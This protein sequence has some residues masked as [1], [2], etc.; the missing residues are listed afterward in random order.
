MNPSNSDLEFKIRR[1][2]PADYDSLI[3]LWQ[4]SDSHIDPQGRESRPNFL[5]QLELFPD[6]YLVAVHAD[7][8]VGVVLGSHDGRKGWINRLAVHP[9]SRRRK[10]AQGL[11]SACDTA[12]RAHGIDLVAALVETHNHS[13]ASLFRRLAYEELPV[14]YFRKPNPPPPPL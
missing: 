4:I 3:E 5:R 14:F 6:L 12:I 8:I 11:V 7:R 9:D 1:A 13:S 10:I 2:T